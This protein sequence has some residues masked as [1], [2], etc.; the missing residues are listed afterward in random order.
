MPRESHNNASMRSLRE[1]ADSRAAWPS[2]GWS[3]AAWPKRMVFPLVSVIVLAVAACTGS[4]VV[5]MTA[6]PSTDNFLVYRVALTAVSFQT[7]SGG[8]TLKILPAPVTVDF[9]KLTDLSEVLGT[10]AS[11][12]GTY[13]TATI[14]LDYSAAQIIYDD[15]SLDGLALSPV[16][17]G[18]KSLGQVSVTV[19]LDPSAPLRLAAK[20]TL[21][22]ALAFDLA[23][24][25]VVNSSA[26]TVTVTP[27]VAASSVPIDTKTVRVRG[28][29][30]GV[31]TT[32][33]FFSTGITPFDGIVGGLGGLTILPSSAV[34]TTYEVNGFP[35]TG[36]AGLTALA[37]L[38]ASSLA[39]AYGT[40]TSSATTSTTSVPTTSQNTPVTP[41]N[42]TTTVA[43][44]TAVSTTTSTVTFTASQVLAGSS[45]QGVGLDRISGVVSARSGNTLGIEDATLIQ[46]DGIDTFIPGTTIVNLGGNTLVTFVGQT[47]AELINPQLINVG[48]V[49]DAF[50]TASTTVTA[51]TTSS[52]GVLLDASAGHVRLDATTASG[53]VTAQGSGALTLSLTALGNRT[54]SGFDFT[55]S[56]AAANRYDV[57]TNSLDTANSSTGAP[58]IVTGLPNAFGT[59]APNLTAVTLLDPNTIQAE[60]VVDWGTGTATPFKSFDDTAID[61][62]TGNTSIG[63]R[64]QIQLGSQIIDL[65][66]LS[67]PMITPSAMATVVYSVGHKSSSTVDSFN[68]YSAFITELQSQLNGA[69]LATGMTAIGQYT[70]STFGFSAVS[71]TLF[72]NN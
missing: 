59:A 3:R 40:L 41:S 27:L 55:G 12:T 19:K 63:L 23:A 56:G 43:Q 37:A 72:L 6:T 45:V 17:A 14:T 61:L 7:S 67:D 15:G 64:H 60:L 8:S 35:S 26:R 1:S 42:P 53:L 21:Q 66:G 29:L 58:V 69:T 51:S 34:A 24:S 28:P 31:N 48:S 16:N 39:V 5:T 4:A 52:G 30:T 46:S 2:A 38:P 70:A 49:I 65:I 11:A 62:D 22:L 10:P 50:G 33:Q 57:A 9:S 18:G 13:T 54:V 44:T 20:Q 71:I 32:N 25:N 47:G 68:T 36:A